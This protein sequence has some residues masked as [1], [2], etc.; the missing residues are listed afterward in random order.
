MAVFCL[1]CS[2]MWGI[3]AIATTVNIV[4]GATPI[5]W[6][7]IMVICDIFLCVADAIE[8]KRRKNKEM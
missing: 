6:G 1:F 4:T 3:F 8:Y 5:I 7:I 2:I